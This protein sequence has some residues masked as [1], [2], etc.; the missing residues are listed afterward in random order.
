M[1]QI[2]L[3]TCL[4]RPPFGH[5]WPYTEAQQSEVVGACEMS[6]RQMATSTCWCKTKPVFLDNRNSRLESLK[7]PGPVGG[8]ETIHC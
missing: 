1:L 5:L 4:V 2:T 7:L 6:G 8:N 3:Q